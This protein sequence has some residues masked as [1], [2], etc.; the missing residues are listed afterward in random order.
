M[1]MK[2]TIIIMKSRFAP[3]EKRWQRT[4]EEKNC[5]KIFK[6]HQLPKAKKDLNFLKNGKAELKCCHNI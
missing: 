4:E 1:I 5:D 2:I 3:Q 6:R